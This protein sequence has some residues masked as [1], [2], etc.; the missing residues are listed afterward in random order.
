MNA[1]TRASRGALIGALTIG[2]GACA[3]G[4]GFALRGAEGVAPEDAAA[5]ARFPADLVM[6]GRT[7]EQA[8]G[9]RRI[10]W[11]G[12]GFTVRAAG[13]VTVTMTDS[14]GNRFDV[15]EG[16][17]TRIL[18]PQAGTHAYTLGAEGVT[19]TI[20]LRRR[21]ESISAGLTTIDAVEA[22]GTEPVAM[23]ERRILFLGDS[24]TAGFGV[25][26]PDEHCGYDVDT[27]SVQDTYAVLA[28]QAFGAD[29]H[30]IAISGRGAIYNYDD[31]PDPNMAAHVTMALPDT[32][33]TWDASAW[34]PDIV[35]INLGT[36]DWSTYD[37]GTTFAGNYTGILVELAGTYP[38]AEILSLTGPLLE[39]DQEKAI[40]DGV[41]VAIERA[42]RQGVDARAVAI[43]LPE[44][45]EVYGCSRHPNVR[46]MRHMADQ[47]IPEIAAETG[48]TPEG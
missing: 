1:M 14:G 32:A 18:V 11:V 36:N 43:H 29:Y 41:A 24:I 13:P 4:G 35:V 30:I 31:H 6:L 17:G 34:T 25:T 2:A 42:K 9:T 8:D 37:P 46:A 40:E 44:D 33:G 22:Y 20:T 39:G 23:P 15:F 48:W 12:S 16:D 5:Q 45:G 21:S 38:D 28:A 47:V 27:S 26:G 7:D 19:Q 3:A 10:G